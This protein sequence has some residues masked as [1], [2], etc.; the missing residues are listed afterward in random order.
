MSQAQGA[1]GGDAP[2]CLPRPVAVPVA[3]VLPS[4]SG[5]PEP[6][7]LSCFVDFCDTVLCSGPHTTTGSHASHCTRFRRMAMRRRGGSSRSCGRSAGCGSHLVRWSSMARAPCPIGS[8]LHP[9]LRHAGASQQPPE[10]HSTCYSTSKMRG[11]LQCAPPFA[12][13]CKGV[14]IADVRPVPYPEPH[15]MCLNGMS[16]PLPSP[17]PLLPLVLVPRPAT[18]ERQKRW[19]TTAALVDLRAWRDAHWPRP[20]PGEQ[21]RLRAPPP[22]APHTPQFP[23]PMWRSRSK[24]SRSGDG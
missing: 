7:L 19:A 23:H 11:V 24:L 22:P 8:G 15:R 17:P 6:R 4:G 13:R 2:C 18:M 21:Q 10:C 12:K 5:A 1:M 3:S 20:P 14:G 16:A 9:A